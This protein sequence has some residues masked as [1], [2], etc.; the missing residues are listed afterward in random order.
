[1]ADA[2][3]RSITLRQLMFWLSGLKEEGGR[4]P[5]WSRES[6]VMTHHFGDGWSANGV[7]TC[8]QVGRWEERDE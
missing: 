7:C 2:E 8:V 3:W 4:V 5:R 1:M 6:R